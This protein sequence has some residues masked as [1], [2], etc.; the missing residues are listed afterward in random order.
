MSKCAV[1]RTRKSNDSTWTLLR[2]K[3][4]A[5]AG[6]AGDSETRVASVIASAL[7]T[8]RPP[9]EPPHD[10]VEKDPAGRANKR[11]S[12]DGGMLPNDV[13]LVAVLISL[14]AATKP[15]APRR[16]AGSIPIIATCPHT[17]APDKK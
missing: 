3:Y 14:F 1:G 8:V 11:K 4:C 13:L 12:R 7:I 16:I 9:V 17:T 5:L 10:E 2:P 6:A 15:P